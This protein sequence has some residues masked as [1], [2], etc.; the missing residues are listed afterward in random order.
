MRLTFSV[1]AETKYAKKWMDKN[2]PGANQGFTGIDVSG[3][4]IEFKGVDDAD[5]STLSSYIEF[6]NDAVSDADSSP[7]KTF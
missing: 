1:P 7:G 4:D 5:G 6:A 2:L 3:R